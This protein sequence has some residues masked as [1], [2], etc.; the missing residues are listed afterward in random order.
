MADFPKPAGKQEEKPEVTSFD[1]FVKDVRKEN[2]MPMPPP[3]A[4]KPSSIP[5]P[6]TIPTPSSSQ[7]KVTTLDTADASMFSTNHKPQ[8]QASPSAFDDGD[9]VDVISRTVSEDDSISLDDLLKYTVETKATDL[10]LTA[11]TPPVYRH[12]GE[13][14]PVPGYPPLSAQQVRDIIY[15]ILSPSA[16]TAF[17][18]DLELNISYGIRNFGRFRVNVYMQRGTVACAIRL[19][20]SKMPSIAELGLPPV[21]ETFADFPRGL[22]LITGPTGS[23]KSTTLAAIIDKIN[24]T[25]KK[26][27]LTI[28]DPVEFVHANKQCIINQREVGND[29]QNFNE[30]L[31]NA[32]R[33]DPDVILLGE[34][35]DLETIRSALT[36]AETGHL[37]FATLHTQSV[38]ETMARIIDVFP[39]GAKDQVR[40]QLAATVQGIACQSLIRRMDGSSMVAAVEVLKANPAIRALI[41]KGN[42]EQIMTIIE[43][44]KQMGMQSLDAH[45]VELV[46]ANTISVDS[47]FEKA[48]LHDNIIRGLGGEVGVEKTRRQQSKLGGVEVKK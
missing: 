43:T 8:Q 48:S 10:H 14:K 21:L 12:L 15:G 46:K 18:E 11:N 44:S 17:E 47:A 35:R 32:L 16:R 42:D 4:P 27:I 7:P 20:P 19:I 25:K 23:G 33:Q 45:L 39:D 24:R 9:S 22:V 6:S 40:A 30:A 37:V 28:E 3:A 29:T 31:R 26:H 34:M 2:G 41:R 36:A 1:M 13:V 38:S 5:A